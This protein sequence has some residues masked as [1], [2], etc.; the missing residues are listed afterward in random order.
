MGPEV[1]KRMILAFLFF[2]VFAGAAF[3]QMPLDP[4]PDIYSKLKCCGCKIEFAPC[5][6]K[7]AVEMKAYIDA[8]IDTGA[9]RKDVYFRL[10]KKF[11][12]NV[13]IDEGIRNE[14]KTQLL[15]E[16]GGKAPE[17]VPETAFFNFGN[18]SKKAGSIQR[19]FKIYNKGNA[20]LVITNI[21]VSCDCVTAF[22][23]VGKNK[24]PV[25][26]VMGD[27]G[28]AWQE[29]IKPG[30][31]G[32]LEIA[33]DMAHPSMEAGRKEVRDIFI[34]SND[35]LNSQTTLRVEVNV[36]D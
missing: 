14:V 6:C 20:D 31:Y 25:F 23:K 27:R 19:A 7:E 34:A 33:I 30:K 29:T 8:L 4:R 13:I 1:T 18:V 35:P 21:R 9:S 26:G 28:S 22:L 24:S 5:G 11:S 16:T 17:I 36:I 32:E 2:S 15:K 12:T 3:A 10:A